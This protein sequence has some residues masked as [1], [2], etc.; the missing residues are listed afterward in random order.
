MKTEDMII[1]LFLRGILLPNEVLDF[2][3]RENLLKREGCTSTERLAIATAALMD[4]RNER[5]PSRAVVD[6]LFN[7]LQSN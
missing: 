3:E 2:L 1:E 4:A 7:K 5:N 6:M